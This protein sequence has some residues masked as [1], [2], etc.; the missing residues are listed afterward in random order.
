MM[1]CA[2]FV[3]ST[4]ACLWADAWRH[5]EQLLLSDFDAIHDVDCRVG[6]FSIV[7]AAQTH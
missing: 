2:V 6:S 4:L 3:V 7:E 5:V 1:Q